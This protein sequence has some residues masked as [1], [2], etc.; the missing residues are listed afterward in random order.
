MEFKLKITTPGEHL[1]INS[2]Q[3]VFRELNKQI[4][5]G[6]LDGV[7]LHFPTASKT[8]V[9]KI[10]KNKVRFYIHDMKRGSW[11]IALLGALGGLL[12]KVAYDLGIDIAKN[13]P[14]F[15][16]LKERING[17]YSNDIAKK[18]AER[19]ENKKTIS[20]YNV[21]QSSINIAKKPD[22]TIVL[23]YEASLVSKK[24]EKVLL[25][26]EEQIMSFL[27]ENDI[28]GD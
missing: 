15:K 24:T 1:S 7:T 26:N 14:K 2:M 21:Q 3:S 8:K 20:S 25:T 13:H 23:E 27:E 19:L 22:G 16:D 28:E 11:E 12:A 5:L 6:L 18:T 10:I 4:E 17:S 9:K